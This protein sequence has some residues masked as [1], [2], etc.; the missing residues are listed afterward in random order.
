ML[1]VFR[2]V[3]SRPLRIYVEPIEASTI[4]DARSLTF[5]TWCS[6]WTTFLYRPSPAFSDLASN[7]RFFNVD[8]L[9]LYKGFPCEDTQLAVCLPTYLDSRCLVLLPWPRS[10]E[11]GIQCSLKSFLGSIDV[12]C[13]L[14]ESPP[15]YTS[16][17]FFVL[18][19]GGVILRFFIPAVGVFLISRQP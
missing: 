6:M 11:F 7:R 13:T 3:K 8:E 12:L 16:G 5:L 14:K 9:I 15:A 1:I 19:H 17:A 10:K 4:E 18:P 2:S